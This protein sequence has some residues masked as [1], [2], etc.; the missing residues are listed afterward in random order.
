MPQLRRGEPRVGRHVIAVPALEP[1]ERPDDPDARHR[2]RCR[3]QRI[4]GCRETGQ[5]PGVAA[6]GDR[7][8]DGQ[9]RLP[10]VRDRGLERRR[11]CA[12]GDEPV[13]VVDEMAK[14]GGP[15][16]RV[17]PGRQ[18]QVVAVVKAHPVEVA[19]LTRRA[20]IGLAAGDVAN[21]L[22]VGGRAPQPALL[23]R[24]RSFAI[25]VDT[26]MPGGQGRRGAGDGRRASPARREEAG[27]REDQASDWP[28]MTRDAGHP[29]IL[30]RFSA[31][32]HRVTPG[33]DARQDG[34]WK[35]ACYARC[36]R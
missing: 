22:D 17:D 11:E 21:D 1:E 29:G 3:A 24:E 12:A 15:T 18:R 10:Q 7:D 31:T 25:H 33:C 34:A 13:A 6:V 2:E 5:D 9:V 35:G 8:S 23:R 30:R 26:A 4:G 19:T 36:H 14:S 32:R 27:E 20:V 16:G 28:R